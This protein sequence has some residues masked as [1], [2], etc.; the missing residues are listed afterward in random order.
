MIVYGKLNYLRMVKG[1]SD[2]VFL[3]LIRWLHR[4]ESDLVGDEFLDVRTLQRRE[5]AEITN[6]PDSRRRGYALENWFNGLLQN[7]GIQVVDPFIRNDGMEQLDGGAYIDRPYLVECKWTQDLPRIQLD[8]LTA[9]LSRSGDAAYGLLL[10]MNGWDPR[11]VE[12]AKQNPLKRVIFM[13]GA[14]IDHLLGSTMTLTELI[15]KKTLA[16]DF[17]AEPYWPAGQDF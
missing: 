4:L 2:P 13:N 16:L 14:D 12:I 3:R 5:F 15:R 10:S 6:I 9:K 1:D 11:L 8:A 7:E 17:R